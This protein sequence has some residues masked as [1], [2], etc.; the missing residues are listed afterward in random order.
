[1][2]ENEKNLAQTESKQVKPKKEKKKGKAKN[3]WKG[4]KSEV[5]K[6]AWPSWKQ[7]LKGSG[8]KLFTDRQSVGIFKFVVFND[9]HRRA[10]VFTRDLKDRVALLDSMYLHTFHPF[11]FTVF[12]SVDAFFATRR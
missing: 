2:A 8:K 3:A 4:F 6:V 1:M 9:L 5:K 10:C 12:Y 7:V 11:F